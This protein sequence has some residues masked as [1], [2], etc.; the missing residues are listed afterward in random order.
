MACPLPF[1]V[2]YHLLLVVG[3]W[4]FVGGRAH[5]KVVLR[6]IRIAQAGVR[7][8]LGPQNKISSCG[9]HC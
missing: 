9:G 1:D 2:L 5:S 6:C 7:F 3:R 4:V 8:S